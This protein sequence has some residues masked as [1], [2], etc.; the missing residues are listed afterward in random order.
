[1]LEYVGFGGVYS[2]TPKQI[3]MSTPLA[4][5][6]VHFEEKNRPL[7]VANSR[8]RNTPAQT[9]HCLISVKTDIEE[10]QCG[11]DCF[12]GVCSSTPVYLK[13]L[14]IYEYFD[15]FHI[16]YVWQSINQQICIVVHIVVWR[17]YLFWKL[18]ELSCTTSLEENSAEKVVLEGFIARPQSKSNAYPLGNM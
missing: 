13:N 10:K 7:T 5:C 6:K 3:K 15:S 18:S 9:Q 11:K 16:Y 4:T 1:M 8:N 2:P 14:D 12:I 17:L